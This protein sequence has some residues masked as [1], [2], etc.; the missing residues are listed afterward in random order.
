MIAHGYCASAFTDFEAS[1]FGQV[2]VQLR[3]TA[4]MEAS[5][6]EKMVMLLNMK[7]Y[8]EMCFLMPDTSTGKG[9]VKALRKA[10]SF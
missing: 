3:I 9:K 10:T 7:R 6:K 4:D 1:G 5:W 8:R 2:S